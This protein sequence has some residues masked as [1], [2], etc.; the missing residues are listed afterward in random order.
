MFNL[1]L[2]VNN[3]H[4]IYQLGQTNS[5]VMPTL[6]QSLNKFQVRLNKLVV[7]FACLYNFEG[8]FF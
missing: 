1:S 7:K 5:S 8:L 2:T 6:S 4:F 3:I